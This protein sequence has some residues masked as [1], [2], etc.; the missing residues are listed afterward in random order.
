MNSRVFAVL[1]T[2]VCSAWAAPGLAQSSPDDLW[3]VSSRSTMRDMST[4]G[5]TS[6]V[7]AKSGERD[8]MVPIQDDCRITDRQTDGDRTT[9]RVACTGKEPMSGTGA[10]TQAR[11]SYRGILKLSTMVDGEAMVITT[12]YSGRLIGKCTAR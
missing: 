6:R 5:T 3:E 7:C 1:A 12:E 11:D 10:M 9:F 8:S 2:A 4:P